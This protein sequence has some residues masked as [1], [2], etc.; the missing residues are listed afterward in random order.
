MAFPITSRTTGE[1]ITAS[2]WNA[3]IKDNL[4]GIQA[5]TQVLVKTNWDGQSSEPSVSAAG[6]AVA[7][8][9]STKNLFRRSRNAAA[10]ETF[11]DT[12]SQTF[13]G[14][15]LRTSP[16]ADVAATTVTL[17]RADE[18]VLDDGTR[19]ADWDDLSA[20]ISSSGAGGL[21]TGSEAAS[22]WYE[23]Y[24][25]RKSSDGTKNLLLHRAK[26]YLLDESQTTVDDQ[27]G[28][29]RATA[30]TRTKG[31]QSFD[32]DVT[33]P[34]ERIDLAWDKDG[35]P[36]GRFWVTIEADA[37]GSPSGTPLATS[38]KLDASLVA[39][40]TVTQWVAHIFRSP[41]TLTAGTTYWIVPQFDYAASDAN[42]LRLKLN[43]AGGYA[44]GLFK[45]LDTG[46]WT[47]VAGY[48]AAFKVYVTENDAA[49]TMPSGYDQ[50]CKV[51][52]VYNDSG[53][54][55]NPFDARDR[56]VY[57]LEYINLATFSVAVSTLADMSTV[58]PPGPVVARVR[59]QAQSASN[60]YAN[61]AGVPWGY[62]ENIQVGHQI[63]INAAAI[64]EGSPGEIPT[65]YQGLYGYVSSGSVRLIPAG[66][67]W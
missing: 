58:L 60:A 40:S 22:T 23:I 52:Y 63:Q 43:S 29:N 7:Y 62:D 42:N 57:L 33:G 26:D 13:R 12:L 46:V 34:V 21:D 17:L 20:V 47:T 51:G 45:T 39:A 54:N 56:T 10:F 30:P 55:L 19:V 64:S 31:G 35:S 25:I 14:L 15:H 28:M 50:K 2:I 5:G 18:I 53:S 41:A 27:A 11:G 61:F 9:D 44:A 8:Y 49:V 6:D 32:T 3:D 4:T 36:S 65:E 24:A 1:L 16:N 48:D 59:F 67:R 37:A 38:D 66:F